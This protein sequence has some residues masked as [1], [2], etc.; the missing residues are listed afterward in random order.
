[1]KTYQVYTVGGAVRDKLMGRDP[2]DFDYVVVGS[3]PEQM[4]AMGFQQVGADFP[5]FLNE[6]GEEFALAR[7]E[8][9]TGK[10]YLG[11]AVETDGVTLA[12][13]LSRRDLTINAMAEDEDGKIIDPWGGQQDLEA[14]VLRHVSAAFGEDPL[15]VV[16]LARFFARYD[17]FSVATE[18]MDL[19]KRMVENG[20]LN[21]LPAERFWAELHKV[22]QEETPWR[23]FWLMKAMHC[24]EN[25]L[26]FEGLYGHI[27]AARLKSVIAAAS[28]VSVFVDE[29]ERVMF[30]TALA[31][32]PSSTTVRVSADTRTRTLFENV[33]RVRT[34]ERTV[35]D[36]FNLLKAAKAWSEGSTFD[37]LVQAVELMPS[38]GESPKVNSFDLWR[39]ASVTKPVKAADF[40]DIPPGKELGQAIEQA[41]RE[42]IAGALT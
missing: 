3:T 28:V 26:F 42:A 10:G 6:R 7:T 16:R 27:D 41:R 37:D 5:V 30:H 14:R 39:A 22:F 2:K 12:D 31:A 29:A 20:D 19:A 1:M 36:V 33:N 21:Q 40:P 9:K 15:R 25:V 18:T 34:M 13:D 35:D 4:I 32:V 11:F 17:N 8:R 38:I 23:F 24:D